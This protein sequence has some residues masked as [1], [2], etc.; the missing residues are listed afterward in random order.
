MADILLKWGNLKGWSGFSEDHPGRE[1]ANRLLSTLGMSAME[2][3]N[4]EQ[5][6]MLCELIDTIDGTITNDWS[7]EQM[8]KDDAK[9]YVREYPA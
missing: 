2:R 6:E 3:L 8:T 9:A 7:G 5:K 4:P 1:V